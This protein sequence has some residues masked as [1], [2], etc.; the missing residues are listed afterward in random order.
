M[1][2]SSYLQ[3]LIAK[4]IRGTAFP[5]TVTSLKVALST[6]QPLPDGTNVSEPSDSAY[7]RQEVILNDPV[8]GAASVSISN[9]TAI[10]F[11][12][13]TAAWGAVAYIAL[14]DQNGNML[15]SGPLNTSRIVPA[16]DSFA[17]DVNALQF[18]M[19]GVFGGYVLSAI[20][21]WMRGIAMPSAPTVLKLALST[22]DPKI[23]AS[24]LAEII[25]SNGYERQ[26]ITFTEPSYIPEYGTQLEMADTVLFG[27]AAIN[28]W[29]A[30]S[31]GAVFD[32]NDNL[33][34]FGAFAA[35]RTIAIGDT[36]PLSGASIQL[37]IK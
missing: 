11:G 28:P 29:N 37:L 36:L 7:S 27:P 19:D 10:T 9:K 31:H 12:P 5:A 35:Q 30:V 18:R 17:L 14:F 23:D 22:A 33:I 4:W 3:D 2:L 8:L 13:A 32:A 21:N 26:V 16:G 1:N 24:G 15:A 6:T 25:T 34:F 20:V